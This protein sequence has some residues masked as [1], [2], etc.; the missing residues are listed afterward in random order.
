M[1]LPHWQ[2]Y[3]CAFVDRYRLFQLINSSISCVNMEKFFYFQKLHAMSHSIIVYLD[4]LYI[5]QSCRVQ[6]SLVFLHFNTA[7]VALYECTNCC[8][9][10]CAQLS[11]KITPPI[12]TVDR[13][14]TGSFKPS[15][16]YLI[17]ECLYFIS[18]IS[19]DLSA[20][21]FAKLHVCVICTCQMHWQCVV[22]VYL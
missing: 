21:S 4:L 6:W 8:I 22:F 19:T 14:P 10:W 7:C 3:E 20:T 15:N 13:R 9:A 5:G 1:L 12:L 18:C 16:T 2:V 11:T 17:L